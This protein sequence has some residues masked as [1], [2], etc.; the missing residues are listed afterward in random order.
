LRSGARYRDSAQA[1]GGDGGSADGG[2]ADGGATGDGG[3]L[4]SG[5]WTAMSTTG[6]PTGRWEHSA[7]WLGSEVIVWGGRD[8]TGAS[9]G[10]GGHYDPVMNRWDTMQVTGA[11]AARSLHTACATGA[12]VIIWGG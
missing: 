5:G 2:I 12:Q 10:T 1:A 3:A 11:P 7:T 8:V 4:G 6:A 9:L